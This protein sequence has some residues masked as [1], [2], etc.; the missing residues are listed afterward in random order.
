M[1]IWILGK[2]VIL[3]FA[4]YTAVTL[5]SLQA[6]INQLTVEEAKAAAELQAKPP[7]EAP[8]EDAQEQ[9]EALIAGQPIAY[10]GSCDEIIE[11]IARERGWVFPDEI[12]IYN[13]TP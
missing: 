12:T 13:R 11:R 5:L 9:N 6:Q 7:I 3:I 4:L 1:K 8:R 2:V 10:D